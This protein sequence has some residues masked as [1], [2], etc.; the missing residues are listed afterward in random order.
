[1]AQDSSFWLILVNP[2]AGSGISD[3]ELSRHSAMLDSSGIPHVIHVTESYKQLFDYAESAASMGYRGVIGHGGDGTVSRIASGIISSETGIPL[4]VLPAGNGNDWAR[5]IGITSVEDTLE[6]ILKD[7]YCELDVASCEIHSSAGEVFHSSIFINSAGIG[8]DAHV[9]MKALK[10]RRKLHIGRLGYISALISTVLEMP[11][12]NGSM[13][14]DEAEVYSG[15]Y[16]SLTSGVCPY[17]GG[18][19]RLSPS[20]LPFDNQLDTALI[21]PISRL[22]L[23]RSIPMV[24]TG[25]ILDHPAVT[26]WRSSELSVEA[27]G[28][29]TVELD[30]E[31]VPDIPDDSIVSL[32]SI[33]LAIR[34]MGNRP[35]I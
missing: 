22:R 16:L 23:I 9:L 30:G 31:L 24:F 19:M 8:L 33:P 2:N 35:D 3:K 11:V 20:S 10:L 12:W 7:K 1:M 29:V 26:S 14:V 6:S 27:R 25:T 21:E 18:G 17:S 4:S 13:R 5:T 34:V 28:K 32:K 15:P